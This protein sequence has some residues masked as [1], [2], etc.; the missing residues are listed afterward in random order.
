ML[1]PAYGP[2]SRAISGSHKTCTCV[3]VSWRVKGPRTLPA[4]SAVLVSGTPK[5]VTAVGESV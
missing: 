2:H 5:G 1:S 4:I 3:T